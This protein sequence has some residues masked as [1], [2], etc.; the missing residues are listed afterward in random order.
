MQTGPRRYVALFAR[1]VAPEWRRALLLGVLLLASTALQLLNPQL[2]RLFIDQATTGA[3]VPD[4]ARIALAFM[5]IALVTQI[6]A[7]IG[8]Y[9]GEDLGWAATN[10]LRA[11]LALHCL[12][13]DLTFHKARTPG[14]LIE[15]VDGD[16]TALANFFSQFVI[17]VLGNVILM[18]GV[19]I[20]L[21]V[22]D[23]RIGAVMTTLAALLFLTLLGVQRVRV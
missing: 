11:D 14:E 10:T 20:V 13:L 19:L 16:V 1:Y 2:L 8:Q 18:L 17:R 7:A 5:A 21:M 22:E 12:R 6:I 4:L 15:R 23:M 3:P 9:V